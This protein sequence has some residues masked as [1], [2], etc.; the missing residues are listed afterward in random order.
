MPRQGGQ[1]RNDALG[2]Q[3]MVDHLMFYRN[4]STTFQ[5]RRIG[6]DSYLLP[7]PPGHVIPEIDIW[8]GRPDAQTLWREGA[9][10]KRHSSRRARHRRRSRRAVTWRRITAAVRQ[11]ANNTPPGPVH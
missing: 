7:R 2:L 4:E 6:S 8:R 1:G 9:R 11:L 3:L 5:V 10:G